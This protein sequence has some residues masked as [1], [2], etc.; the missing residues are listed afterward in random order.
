MGSQQG[1]FTAAATQNKDSWAVQS[2][3]F[4]TAWTK[5]KNEVVSVLNQILGKI[6][7]TT[8]MPTPNTTKT[9]GNK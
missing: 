6:T 7:G 8:T 9:G 4:T 2:T 5:G 1:K 3:E